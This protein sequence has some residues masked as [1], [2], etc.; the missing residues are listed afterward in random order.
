MVV[1]QTVKDH[2]LVVLKIEPRQWL[3]QA[4][5]ELMVVLVGQKEPL[6]ARHK[7]TGVVVEA[8]LHYS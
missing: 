2:L 8:R 6:V 3:A 5:V 7:A 1:R 4:P